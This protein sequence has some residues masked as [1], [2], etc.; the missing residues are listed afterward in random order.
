MLTQTAVRLRRRPHQNSPH[1]KPHGRDADPVKLPERIDRV[2][3]RHLG[4]CDCRDPENHTCERAAMVPDLFRE[5]A[6]ELQVVDDAVRVVRAEQSL[7]S[8]GTLRDYD[9]AWQSLLMSLKGLEND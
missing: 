8:G 1:V 6:P 9:D 7:T 4:S 3:E 5:L 2:L